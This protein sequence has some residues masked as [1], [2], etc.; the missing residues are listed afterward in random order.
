MAGYLNSQGAVAQFMDLQSKLDVEQ[1][2]GAG[3]HAAHDNLT[4]IAGNAISV[5]RSGGVPVPPTT[6]EADINLAGIFY[7]RAWTIG[8]AQTLYGQPPA[9]IEIKWMRERAA[10][11]YHEAR[12]TEQFWLA[13]KLAASS[14]VLSAGERAFKDR[15]PRRIWE[16]ARAS[17]PIAVADRAV[18]SK[19]MQDS[20]EVADVAHDRD[21]ARLALVH[22]GTA[23][24]TE[25]AE[26]PPAFASEADCSDQAAKLRAD[27][28]RA[29][30]LLDAYERAFAAYLSL[31]LECDAYEVGAKVGDPT[32]TAS[33]A[34]RRTYVNHV[35]A[36]L[37]ELSQAIQSRIDAYHAAHPAA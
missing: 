35:D 36:R 4:L 10:E 29:Q 22:L 27:F 26:L 32:P 16:A 15:L 28:Q 31:S 37:V 34:A 23:L 11:L 5:L 19:W 6:V 30:A 18:V 9:Q 1:W 24:Q 33:G 7:P 2:K 12:H 3:D 25:L 20:A 8:G 21:Q 14:Q 17:G 13:A